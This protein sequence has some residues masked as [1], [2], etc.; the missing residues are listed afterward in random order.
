MAFNYGPEY[1]LEAVS[2]PTVL[3]V[4]GNDVLAP[5]ESLE[6]AVKHLRGAVTEK[7]L[8]EDYGHM[9]W[10]WDSYNAKRVAYPLVLQALEG[11]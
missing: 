3:L 6:L 5:P 2:A 9:D 4:G 10:I 11:R 7:H 1:P 8:I